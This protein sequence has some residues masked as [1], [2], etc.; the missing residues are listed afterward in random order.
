MWR[1]KV[2]TFCLILCMGVSSLGRLFSVSASVY[3]NEPNWWY[4]LAK[5]VNLT[6]MGYTVHIP[7]DTTY[8]QVINF[9]SDSRFDYALPV[10]HKNAIDS[11]CQ[12]AD[13][14]GNVV[15]NIYIPYSPSNLFF[16]VTRD[17]TYNPYEAE[18]V[19]SPYYDALNRIANYSNLG[20]ADNPQIFENGFKGGDPFNYIGYSIVN[21]ST[22][23]DSDG[24][25]RGT[26]DFFTIDSSSDSGY[27]YEPLYPNMVFGEYTTGTYNSILYYKKQSNIFVTNPIAILVPREEDWSPANSYSHSFSV[28]SEVRYLSDVELSSVNYSRIDCVYQYLNHWYGNTNYPAYYTPS[29]LASYGLYSPPIVFGQPTTYRGFSSISVSMGQNHGDSIQYSDFINYLSGFLRAVTIYAGSSWSDCEELPLSSSSSPDGFTVT[30]PT[31]TPAI[32]TLNDGEFLN[33]GPCLLYLSDDLHGD[34]VDL[35]PGCFPN[36]A[37]IQPEDPTSSPYPT[38]EP[39]GTPVPTVTNPPAN[40]TPDPDLP[41]EYVI[42]PPYNP[43]QNEF[44]LWG[45]NDEMPTGLFSQY[46]GS[47]YG[48]TPAPSELLRTSSVDANGYV[49]SAEVDSATDVA[50]GIVEA[51]TAF[52][53]PISEYIWYIVGLGV[54]VTLIIKIMHS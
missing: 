9:F 41:I 7:A 8:N 24:N 5:I 43:P 13:L 39:T 34:P 2:L 16:A 51:G 10:S 29:E 54:L 49:D 22:A 18:D 6:N 26:L 15:Q 40:I 1:S 36:E 37:Y 11:A 31:G 33:L 32:R 48:L 28:G 44:P 25:T 50:T 30:R 42:Y 38:G 21:T 14:A 12:S 35:T 46:V 20:F 4:T 53:G 19:P 17:F 3:T 47:M 45:D 23:S 27:L 52:L